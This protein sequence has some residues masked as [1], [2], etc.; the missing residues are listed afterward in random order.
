M[1]EGADGSMWFGVNRGVMNYDGV[2]WKSFSASDGL[3]DR[4]IEWICRASDGSIYAASMYGLWRFQNETWTQIP[5]SMRIACLGSSKS[6]IWVGTYIGILRIVGDEITFFST[7]S[8]MSSAKS[9]IHTEFKQYVIPSDFLLSKNLSVRSLCEDHRGHLWFATNM[10]QVVRLNPALKSEDRS[11]YLIYTHKEDNV[12]IRLPLQLKKDTKGQI[13]MASESGVYRFAAARKRWV[14]FKLPDASL[15]L[16][17]DFDLAFSNNNVMRLAVLNHLYVKRSGTW[18]TYSIPSQEQSPPRLLESADGALWLAKTQGKVFRIDQSKRQ[19]TTFNDL[20]FQCNDAQNQAWYMTSDNQAIC[21]NEGKWTSYSKND[22]LM[23]TVV[24]L[25]SSRSGQVWAIGSH[26]HTASTAYLHKGRW[27]RDEHKDFGECFDA[28]IGTELKNG[29]MLFATH[30]PRR[31][32]NT[33][34]ILHA[35]P[36][37]DGGYTFEKEVLSIPYTGISGIAEDARGE[38]YL[39]MRHLY[40]KEGNHLKPV[41][42][43]EEYKRHL[44]DCIAVDASQRLWFAFRDLGVSCLSGTNW[45]AYTAKEGLGSNRSSAIVCAKDG[46][47]WASMAHG[48]SRF[49]GTHWQPHVLDS[50]L[51]GMALV[52]GS[53]KLDRN[54]FL[55]IN[56]C[57]KSWYTREQLKTPLE[58]EAYFPFKAIRYRPLRNN[59]ETDLSVFTKEVSSE[60]NVF[61]EWS[62]V[63]KW[64]ATPQN[65]LMFSWRLDDG[66]WSPYSKKTNQIFLNLKSGNYQF[67][68]R[69]RDRDF[70]VDPTPARCS[71]V[72]QLPVWR[73]AWFMI[74]ILLFVAGLIS[75]AYFLIRANNRRIIEK[76]QHLVELE[77]VKLRFFTS[78]SHEFRTPLTVLLGPLQSLYQSTSAGKIKEQLAMMIRNAEKLRKL[79]DQI[80]DI[81]KLEAGRM[82][83]EEVCEDVVQFIRALAESLAPLAE[84][85]GIDFK[86]DLP[87]ATCMAWFDV[88][89]FQKIIGN[90]ISNAIKY[91][92]N[93]GS[94]GIQVEIGYTDSSSPETITVKVED[95]GVG[96][97][98]K[99]QERI[100]EQYYRA[101]SDAEGT[102]LG[103]ALVKEL[104]ELLKGTVTVASPLAASIG[105]RFTVALPL[106]AAQSAEV[107]R[108]RDERVKQERAEE[109]S[110]EPPVTGR[111]KECPSLL[112]VDDNAD[113]R[114]FIRAELGEKYRVHEAENGA[115]GLTLATELMPDLVITDVMMPVMDGIQFCQKLK[116][117]V[118][119]CHV[120][121][122]M[123]TARSS[124]DHELE[125]REHG[126]D[127]Y[128]TKPFSIPLLKARITTLL[129]SRRMMRERYSQ[130]IQVEPLDL[131]IESSDQ[132]FMEYVIKTIEKHMDDWEFGVD[133]LAKVMNISAR[134]LRYKLKSVADLT[135]SAFIRTIRLNQAK[136]LLEQHGTELTISEIASLVGFT[137]MSHFG[138]LFKKQ[139]NQTPSEAL[140]KKHEKAP[141]KDRSVD[142]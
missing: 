89:K 60:G 118:L 12:L 38:L 93:N 84:T 67:E 97:S 81:R 133:Q 15:N 11:N 1:A 106:R 7:K 140:S 113:I 127:D 107:D 27:I 22:G 121:V 40:K 138:K 47:I 54:D 2:R 30:Q 20:H 4:A 90:L 128:V 9:S 108:S 25:Y 125:G 63:S 76:Q 49:D 86:I 70:N 61:F 56:T 52:S 94:V 102:G 126:A 13:W 18:S 114:A 39:S 135:P 50:S 46:T 116:A 16:G 69:A 6:G 64:E 132:Q 109:S 111:D 123:L 41:A 31:P 44:V 110:D 136:R 32:N 105:S 53:L 98:E 103:L 83:V 24:A 21:Y 92:P 104:V 122:I 139:F 115:D 68:V 66:E 124:Q 45:I 23:D 112:I 134:S 10:K 33:G 85:K 8:R 120:P 28:R 141:Q 29:T 51:P 58:K 71:F 129:E 59:P 91:T 82:P 42:V 55:W 80:L 72:V 19:W 96:I 74:M 77:Q 95:S 34:G 37:A 88:D 14:G 142:Y 5:I 131:K 43:P 17:K 87:R 73:Q 3:T 79:V 117:D 36:R 99:E 75:L 57:P 35:I 101:E 62:G 100:F 130:Q 119:L 26:G 48:F 78:I 137:D 65:E